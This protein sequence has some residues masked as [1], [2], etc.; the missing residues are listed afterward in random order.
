M[1]LYRMRRFVGVPAVRYCREL[2]AGV[3]LDLPQ[4][5]DA[6]Y[7]ALA[8]ACWGWLPHCRPTAQQLV[9]GLAAVIDRLSGATGAAAAVGASSVV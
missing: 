1:S 3:R 8:R 4:D 6:Q 2:A 7:S 9:D 5:T